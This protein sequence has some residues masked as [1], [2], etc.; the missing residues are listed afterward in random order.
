MEAGW[1]CGGGWLLGWWTVRIS[2]CMKS[3]WY[4]DWL[5]VKFSLKRLNVGKIPWERAAIFSPLA[6]TNGMIFISY[7]ASASAEGTQ[8][9]LLHTC[10]EPDDSKW[11]RKQ[12]VA[13][14][15]WQKRVSFDLKCCCFRVCHLLCYSWGSEPGMAP[16][17]ENIGP[18]GKPWRTL[19]EEKI[20]WPLIEMNVF[21][22]LSCWLLFVVSP[23]QQV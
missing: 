18:G 13:A 17:D 6:N 7:E 15:R 8:A 16:V 2:I 3:L 23:K 10:D 1:G 14:H 20:M 4:Q 21:N 9:S 22:M 5:K 19:K 12:H 11:M